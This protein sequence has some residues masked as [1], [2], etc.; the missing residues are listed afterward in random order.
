MAIRLDGLV[1]EEKQ[2][3]KQGGYEEEIS[4][5]DGCKGN[6]LSAGVERRLAVLV[7]EAEQARRQY[8]VGS[9]VKVLRRWVGW[10][11]REGNWVEGHRHSHTGLGARALGMEV[12]A[13][14]EGKAGGQLET[15]AITRFFGRTYCNN[16]RP[17]A[18]GT[19]DNPDVVNYL[20]FVYW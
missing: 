1:E 6:G 5:W 11:D 3:V 15:K 12:V 9:T 8:Y 4:F 10:Y 14:T 18:A 20:Y 16:Q 7:G 13:V 2:T 19:V 17:D